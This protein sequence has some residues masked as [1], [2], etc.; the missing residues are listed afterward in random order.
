[1]S[2]GHFISQKARSSK[3]AK[4]VIPGAQIRA[5]PPLAGII[6]GLCAELKDG[7]HGASQSIFVAQGG[8]RACLTGP[9]LG[10]DPMAQIFGMPYAKRAVKAMDEHLKTNQDAV[11]SLTDVSK[12]TK[13]VKILKA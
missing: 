11:H 2:V 13:I 9:K 12:K 5:A 7:D 3:M 8:V 1:M 6:A 4:R 10:H